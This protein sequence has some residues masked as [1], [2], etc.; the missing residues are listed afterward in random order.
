MI[1]RRSTSWLRAGRGSRSFF[2]ALA[3]SALVILAILS[4]APVQAADPIVLRFGD[5]LPKT[6]PISIYASKFWMDTVERL[7]NGRVQFQWYPS[8]QLGKGRDILALVQAGAIDVGSIG[9]SYTPDKLPLSAAA[10]LPGMFNS[11]CAGSQAVWALLKRGGIL[12]QKEFAPL[13]LHVVFGLTNPPYEIQTVNRAVAK[14]ADMKGLRL[15]TLGGAS[16][17]AALKLGAV[18]VQMAVSDLFLALQRGTV[19]GRFG[20]F[21]S[22]YANSTQDVL[23][24]STVGADIGSFVLTTYIGDARWKSLPLDIQDAMLQAGDETW[25][26]FCKEADAENTSQAQQLQDKNH[27]V[28]HSMTPD[29]LA[30]WH[31]VLAPVADD[32]AKALDGR[33]KPGS[34]VL[35]AFRAT[36][37]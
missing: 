10:E 36:V 9:P 25:K 35:S 7:T 16:D 32:W 19:D 14:P 28:L 23:N 8:A 15:K 5:D 29:E 22:V 2:L 18:P 20:A 31:K 34:A 30:E 3:V 24:H 37:Q 6:H 17:E 27:W 12:D 21:T 33:G 11:S 13:G 26:N 1:V 4:S